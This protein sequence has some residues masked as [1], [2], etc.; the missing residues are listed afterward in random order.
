MKLLLLELLPRQKGL[1][2]A[3]IIDA[4]I[5]VSKLL[6]LLPRQKGLKLD[7]SRIGDIE[8]LLLELLPRFSS[9]FHDKKD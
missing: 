3:S 9:F 8:D 5:K 6:E 7:R 1:K 4:C 2:P